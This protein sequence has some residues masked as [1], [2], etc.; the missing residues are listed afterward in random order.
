MTIDFDKIR[1]IFPSNKLTPSQVA[2]IEFIVQSLADW[3]VW[4]QAYALAT[5]FHETAQRM[6]PIAEFGGKTYFNKYDGR[7]DLGNVQPGDGYRYRGRGYVQ[8][9]GR[10]NYRKYDLEYNPEDALVPVKAIEILK[11]GM[12][13]G[14][15]T[16]KKLSDFQPNDFLHMRRII[17]AMDRAADIAGYAVVFQNALTN[18]KDT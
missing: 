7:K 2:G 16:G 8:I 11:H 17:N 1:G 4:Q 18:G 15:F 12:S 5:A 14:A 10:T 6:A 13:T 3:P 9:T